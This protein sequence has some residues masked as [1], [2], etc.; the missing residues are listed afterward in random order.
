MRNRSEL[1]LKANAIPELGHGGR[2]VGS[3]LMDLA[4]RVSRGAIVDIGPYLGSTTAYLAMGCPEG[5]PIHA[6]DTWDADICD[7]RAKALKFHGMDLPDDLL[8]MYVDNMRP[9]GANLVV[10][11]YDIEALP[12][13]TH[14]PI[15]LLVDDIG[16]EPERMAAKMKVFGQSLM[17]GAHVLLLDY[18][19][20]EHKPGTQFTGAREYMLAHSDRFRF[21]QRAGKRGALFEVVV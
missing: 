14:G 1:L 9:F 5:T 11:R 10:H 20:Y 13:W 2:E 18:F 6:F 21:L 12:D 3:L 8:P 17:L 19:W 4:C 15:E 7:L 16:V